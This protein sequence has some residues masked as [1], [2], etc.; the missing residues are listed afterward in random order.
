[1]SQTTDNGGKEYKIHI[2]VP[3]I[4]FAYLCSPPV[5]VILTLLK[6]FLPDKIKFDGGRSALGRRYTQEVR[7]DTVRNTEQTKTEHTSEARRAETGNGKRQ[8]SVEQ[9]LS[10]VFTALAAVFCLAGLISG[11]Q[12][13]YEAFGTNDWLSANVLF[14]ETMILEL[15]AA[16]SFIAS[17]IFQGIHDRFMRIRSIVG[18]REQIAISKLAA[19]ADI[20][21]NKA[22]KTL[23]KLINRGEFG[24]EAYLDLQKGAFMRHPVPEEEPEK[25]KE[26]KTTEST[27][28]LSSAEQEENYRAIIL[29]IRRLND[30]I[31][32]FAVS[33][34]IYRIEEHTQNIFDYVTEHPEAKGQIRSFMNYYLPTTLKLLESY[35]RIEKV[36]VAGE[37]MKK[38]KENIEN[39]LDML[40]VGF[41]QQVDQLFRNESMDIDSEISVLETMMKQDGLSGKSDFTASTEENKTSAAASAAFDLGGMAAQSAPEEK[42]E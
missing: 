16:V 28:D 30:E 26:E 41:E 22:K 15:L 34:R 4:V 31:H 40:V 35:S 1:M 37:N 14:G 5:G 13:L 39:I 19:I 10:I 12:T 20:P 36:G 17:R 2:P 8:K 11:G 9:V 38:S 27:F 32:D 6:I 23:Q 7:Q 25:S 21:V 33:E 42:T 18:N 3:V 24:E 29:E